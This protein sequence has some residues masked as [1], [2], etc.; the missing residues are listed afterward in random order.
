MTFFTV[1]KNPTRYDKHSGNAGRKNVLP[2]VM[3]ELRLSRL[4]LTTWSDDELFVTLMNVVVLFATKLVP[5]VLVT[6][7]TDSSVR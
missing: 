6:G 1:N 2:S 4:Q 5:A 7:L 3:C